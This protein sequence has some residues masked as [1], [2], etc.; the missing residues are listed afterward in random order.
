MIADDGAHL[1]GDIEVSN[2]DVMYR[3]GTVS[4]PPRLPAVAEIS[5]ASVGK[6]KSD[7]RDIVIAT[8]RVSPKL[9]I[10][11]TFFA[12]DVMSMFVPTD[13]KN[14]DMKTGKWYDGPTEMC[15]QAGDRMKKGPVKA[16]IYVRENAQSKLE[17]EAGLTA[18]E[19]AEYYPPLPDDRSAN[20]YSMGVTA[21]CD[22]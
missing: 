20:H 8:Q 10:T 4:I 19:S 14:V 11:R 1:D 13:P 15:E 16:V 18:A 7:K 3:S 22:H 6:K 9:V 2:L 21:G 12:D 5:F 17:V